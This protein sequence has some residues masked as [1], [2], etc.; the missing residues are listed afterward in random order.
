M[1]LWK[2]TKDKGFQMNGWGF[3]DE[4]I[5]IHKKREKG[6]T[7]ASPTYIKD[8]VAGRPVFGHPS[9]SGAFRF[10][11]GRSRTSGFSSTSI[12]PA[13]MAISDNFLSTGT[14]LKIEKP[15]KGCIITSC[16]SI[17]GPIVKLS[18]GSVKKI[19]SYEEGKKAYK[20]VEEIIYF[21]DILFPLGDVI[22]R[23]YE[24]LKPGYVEEW[25]LLELKKKDEKCEINKTTKISFEEAK[26]I[27][28]KFAIPLHPQ[29]IFFWTQI[30]K[31]QFMAM[32]EFLRQGVW[33]KD[34]VVLPYEKATREKLSDAKRALELIG[35]EH[36]VVLDNI[37]ISK[38]ADAFLFNLGI[39]NLGEEENLKEKIIQCIEKVK[40]T[41]KV[42]DSVN[43]L[44]RIQIKDKAGT[45]I[46]T[47]MG[48]PEK[49]K[50]RRLTGSPSMLFPV[51][52]EG[53]RM[54]NFMES[55]KKGTIRGDFPLYLCKKCNKESIYR[56]C[57]KCGG[58]NIKK[59]FCKECGV[60]EEKC[61]HERVNAYST[62]SI[63]AKYY[64]E[65]ATASLGIRR[66]E[67][68][69]L[70]KGVRGTSNNEHDTENIAKGILR[71]KHNLAVNKDGTMRYDC[72][73]IA[74]SHFKPKEIGA[75]V[76]KLKNLGYNKDAYGMPFES[77]EQILELK[78]HDIILP[79]CP[80]SP[81]ERA[82]DVFFNMANFIDDLLEKFYK[83]PRY[84][85]LK[86]K[87]DLI[88]H[89]TA[90][91]APHN[92]AGVIARIIGFAKPQGLMASPYMHA[93]M[94]RDC[95]GD[96]A[97]VMLLLD[98]LLNFSR[99]FLPA[100]RGGTQDAPL[101]L[102]SRIRAGEVD[103]QI[104]DFELVWDYPLEL[105]TL[106]EQGKHSS[107]IKIETVKK[108]LKEGKDNFTNTGFTHDTDNFNAGVVN[109]S[110]KS[111][112]S[113][114]DKVRKQ[115]ELVKKIRAVDAS[116]VARL[117]IERHFIRDIRGNL[118]KFAQQEFRCVTCNEKF[119]RP[120]MIG[121]CT[122]CGGKILFT[123]S[124]GSIIKYLEPA[125]ELSRNF[126]VPEYTRQGL[127][128]AKMYIQGIFGKEDTKQ[129]E[130][131][132]WF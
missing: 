27:S 97:A 73:E 129:I 99:K 131:K 76:E 75:S 111:L 1:R 88:G 106:A 132:K 126:D 83:L 118:R 3:L 74:V 92:C 67:V 33:K 52:D 78:P 30:N 23:N 31:V 12:H 6:T 117:V 115:M 100:H 69:E 96:E 34:R 130:L 112:P 91:M 16:D 57:D 22:N 60:I 113:M 39:E 21:G 66:E 14:Q 20:D 71:A 5:I 29:F 128:L 86:K 81:D 124:E 40:D 38:N 13:T 80:E 95:D 79:A 42:L 26:K 44:S 109:S 35:A 64:F 108:R 59:Y 120:P 87:E 90:C 89:L 62:R 41:E 56:N 122:K 102:N 127:E 54:R 2:A 46:G 65:K 63:D 77:D 116:D 68:P 37:V 43:V 17:D 10:R 84:Y 55:I 61:E 9:A 119:R 105:Y 123:I 107:E 82:D 19:T 28:E 11:Y 47:R 50:M 49:A 125:L 110:Y 58:K 103:D 32:L 72:T 104:L 51:G 7:D 36:E 53:G 25:W 48:R 45:F 8:L 114:K 24:L 121:V 101:V 70:V 85:N 98:V 93:A 18:D 94:R 15:T 4:Y